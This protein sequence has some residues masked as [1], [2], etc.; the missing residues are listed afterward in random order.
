MTTNPAASFSGTSSHPAAR[1][2]WAAAAVTLAVMPLAMA[3]AHRSSG[4]FICL[5]ALLAVAAVAAERELGR[6]ID[7][8]RRALLSPI[9]LASLLFL[10]WCIFSIAWSD[11]KATSLRAFGEFILSVAGAFLLALTLPSRMPRWALWALAAAMLLASLVI[12]AELWTGLALRRSLGLRSAAFVFNRPVITMLLL[13]LPFLGVLGARR[14]GGMGGVAL[15]VVVP[16]IAALHV[17]ESGA[18]K[19]GVI[20]AGLAYLLALL[21]PR[22]SRFATAIGLVLALSLAPIVGMLGDRL[23]PDSLHHRLADSH[24]RDRIDIWISFGAAIRAQPMLGAGFGVSPR[25]AET[26]V[27]DRVPAEHRTLLAVGHPHN[28]A[29]QIWTELGIIGAAMALAVALLVLRT[30]QPKTGPLHALQLAMFAAVAAVALVGH[31]A[32]Q[33][34]WA[35]AIGAAIVWFRTIPHED[36]RISA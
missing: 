11:A 24:S 23:L 6:L 13:L 5:S 21:S 26:P 15:L 10:G 25:L 31:G 2:L 35:A 29:V 17:S 8:A 3:L 18:G 33:G 9:G 27:A 7:K 32:W 12:I 34:W 36:S 30:L 4:L 22:S 19:L 1:H 20:V 16:T 28:A 14:K